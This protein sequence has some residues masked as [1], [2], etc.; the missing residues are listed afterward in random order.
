MVFINGRIVGNDLKGNS[1]FGLRGKISL[2]FGV[3]EFCWENV[4]DY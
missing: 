2:E 1:W 4:Y 3:R